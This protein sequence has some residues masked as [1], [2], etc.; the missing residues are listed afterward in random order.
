MT[1][2][3]DPGIND[4]AP[5]HGAGTRKGKGG[6]YVVP[7]MASHGYNRTK[8]ENV[9]RMTASGL[10]GSWTKGTHLHFSTLHFTGNNSSLAATSH[11]RIREG[12]LTGTIRYEFQHGT[13]AVGAPEHFSETITWDEHPVFHAEANPPEYYFELVSGTLTIAFVIQ[14][15]E[16]PGA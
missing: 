13:A 6:L 10:M 15:Y 16:A 7:Q 2:M 4:F 14:G 12:S 5:L 1:K 11:F 3:F 9:V 8:H